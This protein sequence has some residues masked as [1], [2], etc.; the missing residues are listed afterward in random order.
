ME[1]KP[2]S[3]MVANWGPML[4]GLMLQVLAALSVRGGCGVTGHVPY[5]DSRLTQLLWEGL[6][7]GGRTLM[8]ACLCPLKAVAEESLNTLHFASMALRIKSE[9]VIMVDPQVRCESVIGMHF[10]SIVWVS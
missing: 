6:R 1:A 7:G 4:L 10:M 2:V 3:V 8:L 9:P 5:R